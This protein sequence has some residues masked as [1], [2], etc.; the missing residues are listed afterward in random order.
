MLGGQK[1]ARTEFGNI[2]PARLKVRNLQQKPRCQHELDRTE[3]GDGGDGP[4][5]AVEESEVPQESSPAAAR[6]DPGTLKDDVGD[7]KV[8]GMPKGPE[9]TAGCNGAAGKPGPSERGRGRAKV[10][11]EDFSGAAS[12]KQSE[13]QQAQAAGSRAT[14]GET[15]RTGAAAPQ[16]RTAEDIWQMNL[17]L[18]QIVGQLADP[19]DC[20]PGR[21]KQNGPTLTENLTKRWGG[22]Y[23]QLLDKS[24]AAPEVEE[25]PPPKYEPPLFLEETG[26][27]EGYQDEDDLPLRPRTQAGKDTAAA[28]GGFKSPVSGVILAGTAAAPMSAQKAGAA[29]AAPKA[30][31]CRGG[32]AAGSKK[33]AGSSAAAVTRAPKGKGNLV[34]L[35]ESPEGGV[36]QQGR[37]E[38]EFTHEAL[39]DVDTSGGDQCDVQAPGRTQRVNEDVQP[40]PRRGGRKPRVAGTGTAA[41]AAQSRPPAPR[42]SMRGAGVAPKMGPAA[43][44]VDGPQGDQDCGDVMDV[45]A[46]TSAVPAPATNP[47]RAKH[48]STITA[49]GSTV[50]KPPLPP[51]GAT[52]DSMEDIAAAVSGADL[53]TAATKRLRD[54]VAT[55]DEKQRLSKACR[56]EQQQA[57][58]IEALRSRNA[59]VELK[60]RQQ[61]EQIKELK[62]EK[63][64]V[65]KRL[66]S[67][68]AER[69]RDASELAAAHREIEK[70]KADLKDRDEKIKAR[71]MMKD[72]LEAL[73]K[74]WPPK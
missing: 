32:A 46:M 17:A 40:G 63:T 39:A 9:A 47:N 1:Q 27:E 22:N 30:G 15:Q 3:G 71:D 29:A 44:A 24:F 21:R 73:M 38:A 4:V 28:A 35:V 59:E 52:V 64:V 31:G 65:E 69:K 18:G 68:E 11:T 67:L 16:P 12:R 6:P 66:A 74:S 7:L 58:D 54:A 43:A 36:G 45:Q 51:Q 41:T 19:E 34:A 37:E 56:T 26:A 2:L 5:A 48:R 14:H 23:S 72:K 70:L 10:V 33:A 42:R 62:E 57:K 8:S 53:G 49:F 25:P 20:K 61:A 60:C 50:S 55:A 13:G